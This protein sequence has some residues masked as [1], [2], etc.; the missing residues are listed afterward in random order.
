M[1]AVGSAQQ[2]ITILF[3]VELLERATRLAK[4]LHTDRAKLMRTAVQEKVDAET[5]RLR[6]EKEAQ[7]RHQQIRRASRRSALLLADDALEPVRE[8]LTPLADD[9]EREER[10]AEPKRRPGRPPKVKVEDE[11]ASF[12]E[13]PDALYLEHAERIYAVIEEPTERRIAAATAIKAIREQRPLTAP[14]DRVILRRLDKLLIRL[15][16]GVLKPRRV[17]SAEPLPKDDATE[18]PI[19]A[20]LKKLVESS[21]TMRKI[22][23][24]AVKT[25]GSA[26]DEPPS[27]P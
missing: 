22:D 19:E 8:N 27:Q 20:R 1:G 12:L 25:F 13:P 15:Q 16:D 6:A 17:I 18:D 7:L 23:P 10:P 5:A 14:E 2:Q 3:P 26:D 4:K 21:A 24:T 9:G 11:D